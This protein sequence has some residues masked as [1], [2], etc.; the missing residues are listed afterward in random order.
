M[1]QIDDLNIQIRA[2]ATTATN[3]I[4]TLVNSL[5]RLQTALS[6]ANASAFNNLASGVSAL[7]NAMATF[8]TN[9][10]ASTFNSLSKCIEKLNN[11]NISNIG[12]ITGA[13]TQ[14]STSLNNIGALNENAVAVANFATGLSKLGG[15]QIQRAIVNIP[16]LGAALVQLFNILKGAPTINRNIID[17]T[18][19]LA[20]LASQGNRVGTATRSMVSG[21]NTSH[22]ALRSTKN[23]FNNLTSAIGKFYARYFLAIRAIKKLWTA[24]ESSMNYVETYN[25]YSV[26]IRKIGEQYGNMYRQFGYESAEEYKNSFMSRMS[27]LTQKMTGYNLGDN[28]ELNLTD[29]VGLGLNPNDLMNFQAKVLSV[30]NSVGLI[31]ETSINTSKA[32]SMLASDLSSLTNTDISTVMEN[33]TSGLVGQ[34]KVMYKYGV[35]ITA[36]NL[37]TIAF[38]NGITKSVKSMTQSEKMQLRVLAILEQTKIAWG[39]QANT[40]NSVANQYR[41]MK[42]QFSNLGRVIGNLF[43][44]IVQKALPVI[45]GMVVA[46][47]RLFTSLGFNLYGSNWLKDLQDGISKGNVVEDLED[48][49]EEADDA[50]ESVK[51]LS[52]NLQGFDEI[53]KLNEDTTSDS[54]IGST[55]GL[56]DLSKEIAD[57][58]ADYESVWDTALAN[59]ENKINKYADKYEQL[60]QPLKDMFVH[61]FNGEFFEAGE[62]VGT[63]AMKIYNR[64]SNAIGNVD[65]K[66]VGKN[67]ANYY[68]G[69]IS[70]I[71]GKEVAEGIN[72]ALNAIIDFTCSFI[73]NFDFKQLLQTVGEVFTNLDWAAVMEIAFVVSAGKLIKVFFSTL[74]AGIASGWSSVFATSAIGSAATSP[75]IKLG[76]TLGTTLANAIKSPLM[77]IPAVT[78]GVLIA[79]SNHYSKL[80]DAWNDTIAEISEKTQKIIDDIKEKRAEIEQDIENTNIEFENSDDEAESLQILADK[81]FDLANKANKTNSE[82]SLMESYRQALIDQNPDFKGILDD[83]TKSYEEQKKAIQEVIDKMKEEAR[84]EAAKSSATKAASTLL[85]ANNL[86]DETYDKYSEAYNKWQDAEEKVDSGRE[87]LVSMLEKASGDMTNGKIDDDIGTEIEKYI[88]EYGSQGYL[89][90]LNQNEKYGEVFAT[91]HISTNENNY[92]ADWGD[93]AVKTAKELQKNWSGLTDEMYANQEAIDKA[94]IALDYYTGIASGAISTETSLYE[95]QKQK[96]TELEDERSSKIGERVRKERE[97]AKTIATNEGSAA[98]D[99]EIVWKDKFEAIGKKLDEVLAN[100]DMKLTEFINK[101]SGKTIPVSL[102]LNYEEG[103]KIETT[104]SSILSNLPKSSAYGLFNNT[105]T[106]GFVPSFAQGT[107][108][109]NVNVNVKIDTDASGIFR[110]VQTEANNW[111]S[112]TGVPAFG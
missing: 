88:K 19:A 74:S 105:S 68:N 83:N 85:E 99:T 78:A 107:Q 96:M 47:N 21:F 111:Y 35:D 89:A 62:D 54:G 5:S 109:Q 10:N 90:L 82:L 102:I 23:Y 40:V 87:K 94:S 20:N 104:T 49:D 32:V 33:L 26:A 77:I 70:K 39:D 53:N 43:L 24:I 25:Y 1:A 103:K 57:A 17:M 98:Y 30:T 38:A 3:A 73:R 71:S 36:A 60:L 22:K 97:A 27:E 108:Q 91:Y 50:A 46:L 29:T 76:K 34:S 63:I 93:N 100:A 52:D 66:K 112:Q 61:F 44:P 4:N 69:V 45:N 31:G 12:N 95:Y 8:K 59:S 79:V 86:G 2:N 15:V 72:N 41:I 42:Q 55:D 80:A 18:N 51:K 67:L 65:W 56:I 101:F 11:T 9:A 6:G 75:L 92:V 13:L 48:L 81:Y 64:I 28:G 110:V 14:F 58:L 84:V 7:G 106:Q 16:Q 37:E